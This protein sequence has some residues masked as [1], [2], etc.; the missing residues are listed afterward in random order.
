[1]IFEEGATQQHPKC[2]CLT[3]LPNR[4]LFHPK[5]TQTSTCNIEDTTR[6]ENNRNYTRPYYPYA[7]YH[8]WHLPLSMVY[9]MRCIEK[10]TLLSTAQFLTSACW[11]ALTRLHRSHI[12]KIRADNPLEERRELRPA[13]RCANDNTLLSIRKVYS[14]S[15]VTD[16]HEQQ[17]EMLR[18]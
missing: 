4:N 2:T 8:F 7:A 6:L 12:I 17:S 15:P 9:G 18:A 11:A 13:A 14:V 1:M 10:T 16:I 5:V 3:N